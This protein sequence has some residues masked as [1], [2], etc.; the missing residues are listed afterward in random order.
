MDISI[1]IGVITYNRLQSLKRLLESIKRYTYSPYDLW[2]ADAGST[3]GTLEW[4]HKNNYQFISGPQVGVSWNKNRALRMLQNC[5][6]IFLFED[7]IEIIRSEWEKIYI[8]AIKLTGIQHFNYFAVK[9]DKKGPRKPDKFDDITIEYYKELQ[10]P[11]QVFTKK[12]IAALGGFSY[13][14]KEGPGGHVDYTERIIK[15]GFTTASPNYASVLEADK[16]FKYHEELV[17]STMTKEEWETKYLPKTKKICEELQKETN[18][19]T[20]LVPPKPHAK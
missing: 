14:Y 19:Y 17:Y 4:L 10:A 3:D 15:A 7:D 5:D 12:V 8:K 11:V 13:R 20:S 6:Y 2:V 1:G 9:R 18:L 16:C